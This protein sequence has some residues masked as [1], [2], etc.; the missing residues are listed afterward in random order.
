MAGMRASF[1]IAG[2][3]MP[4]ARDLG[5]IDQR[6][7]APTIARILRVPFPGAEVS[8]VLPELQHE[9]VKRAWFDRSE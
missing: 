7:I 9:N 1:L 6:A 8:A 5:L 4:A 2:P 3:R